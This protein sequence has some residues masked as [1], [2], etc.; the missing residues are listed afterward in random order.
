MH[1]FYA[2]WHAIVTPHQ[3][4]RGELAAWPYG[5]SELRLIRMLGA[6][7]CPMAG[8]SPV[9]GLYYH[10]VALILTSAL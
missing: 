6:R 10:A 4:I 5:V 9:A 1:E 2:T 3:D 8:V 7:R